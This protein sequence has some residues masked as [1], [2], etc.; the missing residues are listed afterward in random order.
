[1]ALCALLLSGCQFVAGTDS[2][3][4]REAE[5]AVK[6]HLV[7]ADGATFRNMRI[8]DAAPVVDGNASAAGAIPSRGKPGWVCGELN[9]RNRLGVLTGFNPVSYNLE[10]KTVAIFPAASGTPQAD[11]AIIAFPSVCLKALR[12]P[13]T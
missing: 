3:K 4:I 5:E 1:M 10:T 2:Y 6:Y 8:V 7:D 9:A 13:S 11:A 12:D